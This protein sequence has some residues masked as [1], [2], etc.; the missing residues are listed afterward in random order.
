MLDSRFGTRL[1]DSCDQRVKKVAAAQLQRSLVLPATDFWGLSWGGRVGGSG[2]SR[3]CTGVEKIGKRMVMVSH[4]ETFIFA[5]SGV[6][7][8]E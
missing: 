4:Q 6:V 2:V 3:M 8:V 7:A 1:K 5:F